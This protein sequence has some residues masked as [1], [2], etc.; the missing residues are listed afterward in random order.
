[1]HRLTE[2]VFQL[3]L[4]PRSAVNAYLIG[5]VLVDAGLNLHAKRIIKELDGHS[6][7][8]HA[9]THAHYDHA[10]GS[11]R[12]VDALEIPMWA[13]AGDVADTE[14]GHP[15]VADVFIKPL[16]ARGARFAGIPVNRALHEG[17]IVGPGFVV[18]DVPG[19]SPGHVAYWR[20]SDRTLICGDVFNNMNLKTTRVGL[21]EPPRIYTIDPAR[22]RESARRLAAL[23]P[24]LAVF[25]HGPPLR[26]PAKMRAFAAS[27]PA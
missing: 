27:L 14:S 24:E 20:E 8:A 16:L 1:M 22:N 17:D 10:G 6:V 13:P 3:A 11:K 15:A 4:M 19:H 25:G 7:S 21:Q 26:D 18:L 2:D 23:E 5:D 9:L 12:V